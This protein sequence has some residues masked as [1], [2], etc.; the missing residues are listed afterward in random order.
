MAIAL[1]K[2]CRCPGKT[3]KHDLNLILNPD[4]PTSNNSDMAPAPCVITN[5][6][7]YIRTKDTG[8]LRYNHQQTDTG[9]TDAVTEQCH[10]ARVAAESRDVLVDPAQSGSLI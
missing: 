3:Q 7:N 9:G 2:A 1:F 6:G 8:G 5:C 4:L 10:T